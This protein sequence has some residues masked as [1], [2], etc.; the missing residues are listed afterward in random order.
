VEVSLI[1]DVPIEK[2]DPREDTY[3]R[4]FDLI[5]SWTLGIDLLKTIK[6]IILNRK[7]I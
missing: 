2:N 1:C 3:L 7:T 6:K 4:D 5:I